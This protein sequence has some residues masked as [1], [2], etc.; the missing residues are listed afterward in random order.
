MKRGVKQKDKEKRE[1]LKIV[2]RALKEDIGRGD[3]T[4]DPIVTDDTR[5]LGIIFP[6]QDGV[7]CGVE[8]ARMVFTELDERIDFQI[9][10]EDG[11]P[12][13]PGMTIATI[14][15][16]AGACLKGERTAL[17][18]LQHLSGIATLTKRF[19]DAAKGCIKVLDTRKTLPGLRIM[20][21]YAVRMGGGYNHRFGLY[22][23][24][25]IKDNHIEIAGG[26]TAA[27]QKIRKKRKKVFIEVEVKT[28]AELKEAIALRVNRIMLDNMNVNQ[29]KE[30][31]RMVRSQAENMEIEVSGGIDLNNIS[32]FIE[33]GVDFVSVGALT[34][35]ARAID[36]A[37]KLK[38]L[39]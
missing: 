9:K 7:L 6:K 3:I 25:L 36:I 24:V 34:H 35:S 20:E 12:F 14:I 15:G 22:D 23:R 13:S 11:S 17:N 19:V 18:F 37:M 5:S 31:V 38:P 29:I 39:G 10:L 30:A 26:I 16:P 4:T 8:I 1:F 33:C 27:V 32:N 2:R 28:F 21:K